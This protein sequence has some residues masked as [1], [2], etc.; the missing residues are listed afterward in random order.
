MKGFLLIVL[1]LMCSGFAQASTPDLSDPSYIP[2]PSQVVDSDMAHRAEY[3]ILA[4]IVFSSRREAEN[5]LG[6]IK[7]RQKG[8][9]GISE[10]QNRRAAVH[11]RDAKSGETGLIRYHDLEPEVANIA[12]DVRVPLTQAAEDIKGPICIAKTNE[13]II[14]SVFNR[15][16]RDF[17][18]RT[19]YEVE[20]F[21]ARQKRKFN[22]IL[23]DMSSPDTARY[24]SFQIW[25]DE[26]VTHLKVKL[27]QLRSDIASVGKRDYAAEPIEE[28]A[29]VRYSRRNPDM[30]AHDQM[31]KD[32][33]EILKG[34]DASTIEEHPEIYGMDVEDILK[35]DWVTDAAIKSKFEALGKNQAAEEKSEELLPDATQDDDDGF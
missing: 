32:R 16:S 20:E 2:D 17:F 23:D 12:F 5:G 35:T 3:V 30:T 14:F 9:E 1:V 15:Y 4:Q 8:F 29:Q 19:W 26:H 27:E 22:D 6:D 18:S 34:V 10:E 31:M 7:L 25:P 28:S 13:C 11:G 24:L 33:A 21:A